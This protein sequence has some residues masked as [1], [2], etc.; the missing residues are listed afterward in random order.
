MCLSC[1]NHELS[2]QADYLVA[3]TGAFL[4]LWPGCLFTEPPHHIATTSELDAHLRLPYLNF[5]GEINNSSEVMFQKVYPAGLHILRPSSDK[6]RARPA[7][8][9]PEGSPCGSFCPTVSRISINAY[10]K[11]WTSVPICSFLDSRSGY[12]QNR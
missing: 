1:E 3:V 7:F 5:F 11:E 4:A 2:V 8:T 6:T 10:L 12:L 9:K